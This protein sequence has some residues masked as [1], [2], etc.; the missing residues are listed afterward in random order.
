VAKAHVFRFS[1]VFQGDSDIPKGKELISYASKEN[2][3]GVLWLTEAGHM[4]RER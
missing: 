3:K 1:H 2:R 4:L